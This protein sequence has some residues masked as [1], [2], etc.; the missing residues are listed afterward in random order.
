M[1]RPPRLCWF[2]AVVL[3]L[4]TSIRADV[5]EEDL[6]PG[7][8]ATYTDNAGRQVVQLE[9]TIALALQAGEAP[10][11]RLAGGGGTARWGGYLKTPRAGVY[12]F[13]AI[14]RGR[15]LFKNDDKVGLA[16]DAQQANP[17]GQGGP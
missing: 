7:L 2:V 15:L 13:H 6:R 8:V 3:C 17:V 4:P 1:K 10:H 9:P 5:N 12:Q 16:A 11:P 14:V